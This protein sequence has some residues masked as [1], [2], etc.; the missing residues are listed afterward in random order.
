M[1]TLA[2]ALAV[3]ALAGCDLFGGDVHLS[4]VG[5]VVEDD[6]PEGLQTYRQRWT[7]AGVGAYQ[8]RYEVLIDCPACDLDPGYGGPWRVE[9][10]EGEVVERVYEGE[11]DGVEYDPET[12]YTVEALF[13]ELHEAFAEP[14]PD[15]ETEVE[16][17]YS[18]A[19]GF[20]AL[21]SVFHTDEWGE[22]IYGTAVTVTGF[23]RL[24]G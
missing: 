20:P 7:A 5:A 15:I 2:C 4:P 3:L 1:R 19:L 21:T 9:V 12:G 11:L 6:T 14:A 24:D 17:A 13:D 10:R 23:E 18:V 22:T 16:A 8:F